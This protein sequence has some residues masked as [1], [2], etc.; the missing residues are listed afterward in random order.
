MESIIYISIFVVLTLGFI[1]ITLLKQKSKAEQQITS[2]SS[3]LS[4]TQTQ[5]ETLKTQSE[6]ETS[7]LKARAENA[8][9][10]AK[11]TVDQ[12]REENKTLTEDFNQK[13]NTLIAESTKYKTELTSLKELN[14]QQQE[15]NK[16]IG[17]AFKAEFKTLANDILEDKSRKLEKNSQQ[18]LTS[19][20]NPFKENISEFQKRINQ[21]H[22]EDS[23]R[24][25]EL[26]TEI[27]NLLDLNKRI[28]DE[29]TALTNALKGNNKVQ[30]DWGE[31]ILE[32]ILENSNLKKG[33]HFSAQESLTD[34]KGNRLRPDFILN[35]PDNKQIIIDSKV[36]LK[37]FVDFQEAS[38]KTQ[39]DLYMKA[40]IASIKNHINELSQK[41]YQS[42][43]NSLDFVIMFI[44]SESAFLAAMQQDNSLWNEAYNKKII[45]S[46]PTN[47]FAQLKMVSDLWKREDQSKQSQEIAR[48][49]ADL[50]DKFI[51]FLD[52]LE[53]MGKGLEKATA[54][55]EKAVKQMKT[56]R[57]NLIGRTQKMAKMSLSIN[58]TLPKSFEDF[59]TDDNLEK[60][61][62]LE[63]KH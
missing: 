2:L 22:A 4:G 5:Y 44:P 21:I 48:Q 23:T 40:H 16:Q 58:K 27:K 30:G 60:P 14:T 3:E 43:V 12:L 41:N 31:M 19:L 53:D 54:S 35:L 49:G 36:S 20:I 62:S 63:E 10:Q 50:Y 33:V 56:G 46:S 57:G 6:K 42:L 7:E 37:A 32:K 45:I 15:Q 61:T 34:E 28:T 17:D 39:E 9:H 59:D 11:Q 24:H 55:Y 18:T 38:D 1:I 51:G 26:K 8:D 25:G 47:L 13:I 29:T 52:S